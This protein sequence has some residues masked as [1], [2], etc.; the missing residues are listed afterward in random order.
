MELL[1]GPNFY[2][3]FVEEKIKLPERKILEIILKLSDALS[4]MHSKGYAHRDLKPEN[5][6]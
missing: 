6:W 2:E 3:V 4:H 5:I 1:T